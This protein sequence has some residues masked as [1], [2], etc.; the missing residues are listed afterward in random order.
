MCLHARL[1]N[2]RTGDPNSGPHLVQQALYQP[3]ISF[4][5]L[6]FVLSPLCLLTE[7]GAVTHKD[8]FMQVY[9]VHGAELLYCG[10]A[11]L[12][13]TYLWFLCHRVS[14][15]EPLFHNCTSSTR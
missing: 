2:M 6:C 10:S 9:N 14:V 4:Y 1:F 13:R 11:P 8:I 7:L 5:G 12:P 15:P 3:G